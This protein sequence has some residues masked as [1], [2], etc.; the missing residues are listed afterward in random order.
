MATTTPPTTD[1]TDGKAAASPANDKRTGD[2]NWISHN[3]MIRNRAFPSCERNGP[4][5]SQRN[6]AFRFSR[7]T[8]HP[9]DS[10][11]SIH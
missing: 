10:A 11:R 2:F 3:P 4:L 9:L 5:H 1:K 8:T 7:P 6:A